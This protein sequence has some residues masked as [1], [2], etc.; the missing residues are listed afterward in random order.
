M[1]KIN[2]NERISWEE[3]FNHPFFELNNYILCEDNINKEDLNK[4][5]QILNY[6]NEELKERII[7]VYKKK[8]KQIIY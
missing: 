1:L 5:T 4:D 7:N 2:I 8:E 6:L 3:Y